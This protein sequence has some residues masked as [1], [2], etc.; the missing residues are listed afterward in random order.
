[1]KVCII[2]AGI[3][4]RSLAFNLSKNFE[5]TLIADDEL[6]PACSTRS[7]GVVANRATQEGLSDLGDLNIEA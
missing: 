6:A 4:A 5:V 3:A 7:T 2:G 1:M